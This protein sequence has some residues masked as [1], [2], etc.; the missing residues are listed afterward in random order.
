MEKVDLSSLPGKIPI[1]ISC[2]DELTGGGL[3]SFPVRVTEAF[4]IMECS[5]GL[6]AIEYPEC[7]KRATS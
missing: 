2:L 5:W 3:K 7:L 4:L 1:G 6:K